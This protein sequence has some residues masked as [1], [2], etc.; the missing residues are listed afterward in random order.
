MNVLIEDSGKIYS[1]NNGFYETAIS[2]PLSAIDFDDGFDL[3]AVSEDDWR[4]FDNSDQQN[5]R[6]ITVYKSTT[7]YGDEVKLTVEQLTVTTVIATINVS[8]LEIT[9]NVLSSD[10]V[11]VSISFDTDPAG[12]NVQSNLKTYINSNLFNEESFYTQNSISN[13]I[14]G[15]E[16]SGTDNLSI[17]INESETDE[18]G[19]EKAW[20]KT[21]GD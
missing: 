21:A 13:T 16:F 14:S 10:D 6:T 7:D 18:A 9:G 4:F 15:A 20:H 2:T 19:H 1:Y 11:S 3:A 5:F 17:V 12:F 8:P